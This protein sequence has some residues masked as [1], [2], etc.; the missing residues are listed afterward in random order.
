MLVHLV[1]GTYELFRHHFAVPSHVDPDGI[2]VAATRGVVGSVL[3]MLE[4][5]ATHIGVA[6]DHVVESFRNELY[7]GY[8]TSEGMDPELLAQ[9]CVLR[10]GALVRAGFGLGRGELLLEFPVFLFDIARVREALPPVADRIRHA[11]DGALDRRNDGVRRPAEETE[12]AGP[13]APGIQRD[14]GQR[15]QHDDEQHRAPAAR[16]T[17]SNHAF[18]VRLLL[19]GADQDVLQDIEVLEALP[20]AVH[21]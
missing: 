10:R 12:R 1:D 20:G 21:N 4:G 13:A 16:S 7:A 5:G 18:R 15:R 14:Q 6:T 17:R 8:K 19:G 3:G 9:F 11:V 2:E